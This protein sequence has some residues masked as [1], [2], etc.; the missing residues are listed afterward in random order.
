MIKF[1][2]SRMIYMDSKY[3]LPIFL[4]GFLTGCV[5]VSQKSNNAAALPDAAA[6]K[7]TESATSVSNSLG[8]IAGIQRVTTAPIIN[9]PISPPDNY[10]M[11]GLVS[12]DW[13]GPIGPLVEKIALMSGYQ[14]NPIGEPPAIPIIVSINARDT[15]LAYILRNADFQ[16]DSRANIIVI[17][18]RRIIELRYGPA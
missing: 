12:I 14:F 6:I 5:G 11:N 13:S 16:A 8:E 3:I 10:D 2:F 7:L 1:R 18:C 4:L 15:P 17:P 9:R